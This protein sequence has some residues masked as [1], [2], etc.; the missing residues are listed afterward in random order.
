M[1]DLLK[2][3]STRRLSGILMHPTSLPGIYGIGDLGPESYAFI[4]FLKKAGQHIWQ[5]LPLGPT[6]EFNCPYQCFSSFAGQPLLISP[7]L[8]RRDGLLTEEDL[9]DVPEFPEEK[10][11][12]KAVR[13][14]KYALY[15]K[16]YRAFCQL[17]DDHELPALF[18]AFCQET[19]WLDDYAMFMAIK[20]SKDGANWLE[21]EKK[22]RKPTKTQRT[23]IAK[24]LKEEIRYQKFLQW[25]FFKQWSELRAYANANEILLIGDIPI[26]VSPDSADVW[27]EPK[28]FQ[29]TADGYPKVVAGVPPDYFSETG[30][31]WGNPLYNWNYHKKTGYSWWMKR[32]KA[33]LA[34]S[35]I[36]RIDHFR[37]LESYWE[38]PADAETALEGKWKPGPKDAFFETIQETFGKDLPIIAEDLGI[39]TDDVRALRD[40]F[41]LPGMNILQF[42]FEGDNSAYLPYN[43]IANSVCYTG[44]HDNNTTV[45]WY[46]AAPEKVRDKVRRYMNTDGSS[47]HWDFIRTCF[48]CPARIAIVPIQDVFG[49][50]E[51]YRMNIPGVAED[52]W[53]YRARKELFEQDW[54][55]DYLNIV[56]RLY[57][58]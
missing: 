22:Y 38:V 8:L 32:I 33:Q 29:V 25:V 46:E 56:T 51:E 6:G 13:T 45:G 55:C 42:A 34:L 5:T 2:T 18:E 17:E 15:E 31:L 20:D 58:R 21:W 36:I 35:D 4:D 50:G 14:Y 9:K 53:A 16:A 39:I 24:E 30:Q 3:L 43:Q 27:A 40:R 19:E 11:D 57:G 48:G 26:F 23:S 12:Y 28:M 47:I 52:N 41:Q 10:V 1:N 54:I 49:Q 37:G 7:D 44:T